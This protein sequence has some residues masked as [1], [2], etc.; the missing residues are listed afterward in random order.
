MRNDHTLCLAACCQPRPLLQY[1]FCLEIHMEFVRI[2]YKGPLAWVLIDRP[3]ALNALNHQVLSEL[4]EAIDEVG[5]REDIRCLLLTG[6]GAKA[7]VAG[8]DII[9]MGAL[10]EAG[11]LAFTKAG[12]R[13]MDGLADMEIPTIAV[14]NGFA[15]GGGAELAL[16]CDFIIASEAALFGQPEVDLGVI[17]G[18]GGTQRLARRIGAARAAE[19]IFTG[20]RIDAEEALRIGLAVKM[21]APDALKD[22]AEKIA[23]KIAAKGPVAIRLAKRA[24]RA[25]LEM[26]IHRGNEVERYAF[27]RCFDTADQKEGMAAFIEKRPPNFTGK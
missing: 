7:F 4:Q 6:G 1:A 25:G 3:K 23:N 5:K 22:E 19:L 26:D 14:V 13:V 9:E 24:I 21:V 20:R 18:F 10:D 16:A 15:L 17:P 12:H 27:A 11:A 2:E 8:A